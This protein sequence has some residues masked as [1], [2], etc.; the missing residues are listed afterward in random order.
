[1]GREREVMKTAKQAREATTSPKPYTK[2]LIRE[3]VDFKIRNGENSAVFR[4]SRWSHELDVWLN[5]L[6]YSIVACGLNELV[7]VSW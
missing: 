3:Y 1:M 6:G 4:R 2:E 5:G 7:R